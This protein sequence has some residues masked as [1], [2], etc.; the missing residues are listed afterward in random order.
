MI[1][2]GYSLMVLQNYDDLIFSDDSINFYKQL[3]TFFAGS[4]LNLLLCKNLS[5]NLI[6]I[7]AE[8]LYVLMM[9]IIPFSSNDFRIY[10]FLLS[11]G[12]CFLLYPIYSNENLLKADQRKYTI[13]T[14]I[15]MGLGAI[16][17]FW[18]TYHY[19]DDDNKYNRIYFLEV[20]RM[21]DQITPYVFGSLSVLNILLIFFQKGKET[22]YFYKQK[23]DQE[24]IFVLTDLL[25]SNSYGHKIKQELDINDIESTCSILLHEKDNHEKL[26]QKDKLKHLLSMFSISFLIGS[27]APFSSLVDQFSQFLFIIQQ[28]NIY[29]NLEINF[30][31]SFSYQLIIITSILLGLLYL[32][33]KHRKLILI[34]NLVIV[35]INR[36][37]ELGYYNKSNLT[38]GQFTALNVSYIIQLIFNFGGLGTMIF[39]QPFLVLKI[40]EI[41]L[42]FMFFWV[43]NIV[44]YV[45]VYNSLAVNDD[46]YPYVRYFPQIISIVTQQNFLMFKLSILGI[47]RIFIV[48]AGMIKAGYSLMIFQNYEFLI[49]SYEN[50]LF[51]KYF[52]TF[53]AG[54]TL[55]LSLNKRISRNI[56]LLLAEFFY[57]LMMIIIP[58]SSNDFR[59]YAFLFSGGFC[60]LLYPLYLNENLL[61]ADYRKS[62]IISW[63]F[64]MGMGA[65]YY[66]WL[67][68][69]YYQ[70]LQFQPVIQFFSYYLIIHD[71]ITPYV[72]GS[73]SA[74]NVLLI[75]LQKGS[76]TIFFYEFKQEKEKIIQ[77]SDLLYNNSYSFQIKKKYNINDSE[78][79]SSVLLPESNI[80]S[81]Q[82]KKE[83]MKRL[84]SIFASAFL[85]G[86]QAPFNG[87]VDSIS[88]FISLIWDLR[89]QILKKIKIIIQEFRNIVYYL[90]VQNSYTQEEGK[91][92]YSPEI[93]SIVT[94]IIAMVLFANL[95]FFRYN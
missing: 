86:S 7:F 48:I 12:F 75:L 56:I 64:M 30:G 25:Y 42:Y 82:N 38:Q 36:F 2:A 43:G 57:I 70:Q 40:H 32:I 24:Q 15:F 93:I 47:S 71:K 55:A 37:F 4:A 13:V 33:N 77:L 10:G 84:V 8:F 50:M 61:K 65:I 41:F 80:N 44:Q 68:Y 28:E 20:L 17:F 11:G 66:I 83:Q 3:A 78:S 59:I 14:W 89:D 39:T 60:F 22:I 35:L 85:I 72:F 92:R 51:Y 62:I 26:S 9:I 95:K 18:L 1:K 90:F 31:N 21:T 87:L 76:E 19:L 67:A 23:Q 27:Q 34:A 29:Q 88:Y 5:R 69:H 16:Y 45:F 54:S 94:L 6:L 91:L 52:A 58:F 46:G 53:F 49:F 79:S 74:L 63:F 81:V 73:F